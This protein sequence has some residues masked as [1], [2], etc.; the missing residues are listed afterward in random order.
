MVSIGSDVCDRKGVAEDGSSA[1]FHW[2]RRFE[3]IDLVVGSGGNTLAH[4]FGAMK[5]L[6]AKGLFVGSTR[7]LENYDLQSVHADP[8]RD[9]GHFFPVL[10][11]KFDINSLSEAWLSFASEVGLSSEESFDVLFFGGDGSGCT[12]GP[13]DLQ[14]ILELIKSSFDQT[15]RRWLISTSRRTPLWLEQELRHNIPEATIA[16]ACWFGQGDREGCSALFGGSQPSVR[17]HGLSP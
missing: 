17:V 13:A 10:P 1:L 16:D 12:W 9:Y 11:P 15:G 4:T 7:G 5:S 3:S 6:N 14:P 2:S 8:M